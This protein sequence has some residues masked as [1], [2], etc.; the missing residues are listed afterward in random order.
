MRTRNSVSSRAPCSR[1]GGCC[2]ATRGAAAA[3]TTHATR[4]CSRD[5]RLPARLRPIETARAPAAACAQRTALGRAAVG[6]VDRRADADRAGPARTADGQADPF[7][8]EH[9]GT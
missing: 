6:V 8:A 9:A 1:P 3:W 5:V 2:A 4:R 7:D